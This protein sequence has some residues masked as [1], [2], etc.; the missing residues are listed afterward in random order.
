MNQ[1]KSN[2]SG[3][4][5]VLTPRWLHG[6]GISVSSITSAPV[7]EVGNLNF[8]GLNPNWNETLESEYMYIKQTVVII[9]FQVTEMK[10]VIS[11]VTVTNNII[12]VISVYQL[13]SFWTGF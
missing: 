7:N 2:G 6:S 3:T 8:S 4:A 9:T 5:D 1:T 10:M 12:V 11:T 13:P